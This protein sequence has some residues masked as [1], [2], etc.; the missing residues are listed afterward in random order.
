M[1]GVL[2]LMAVA[3]LSLIGITVRPTSPVISN[4]AFMLAGI[5]FVLAVLAFF[6]L[7]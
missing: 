6:G 2:L 3:L 7:I 1:P 4:A 5:L